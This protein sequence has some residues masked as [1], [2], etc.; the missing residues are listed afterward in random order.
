[1][2]LVE[3]VILASSVSVSANLTVVLVEA[4][5]LASLF[6]SVLIIQ[7]FLVEAVTLASLVLVH[8]T[9]MESRVELSPSHLF[10]Q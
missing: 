7:W 6:P 9:E 2:V 3:A 1:M 8:A 4:V 5:T 10:R